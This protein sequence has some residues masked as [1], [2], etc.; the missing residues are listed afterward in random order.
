MSRPEEASVWVIWSVRPDLA[1]GWL[2]EAGARWPGERVVLAGDEVEAGGLLSLVCTPAL[3]GG[4]RMVVVRRAEKLGREGTRRL[5]SGLSRYPMDAADRLILVDGSAEGLVA[6][7]V[8]G[9]SRPSAPPVRVIRLGVRVGAGTAEGPGRLEPELRSRGL[10]LTGEARRLLHAVLNR[11]PERAGVELDKLETY[12][13]RPLD[14]GALRRLL[15]SD[16]LEQV[17]PDDP[18]VSAPSGAGEDRRRFQAVEAALGGDASR[19]LRLMGSLLREGLPP[20]WL[21]RET[22]RQAMQL[23]TLAEALEDRY[24]PPAAWPPR[25]PAD[26]VPPRLPAPVLQRQLAIARRLGTGGLLQVLEWAASADHQARRG[27]DPNEALQ[28]LVLRLA[29]LVSAA[30]TRI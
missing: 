19:A 29:T 26:L 23:W 15:A 20:A 28:T 12:P 24:G 13:D 8:E 14:G 2:R 5:L 22:A 10:Q 7:L 25:V 1:E 21:W 3:A 30:R 9:E 27:T 16:L 18:S 17:D 11:F 6:S 4:P